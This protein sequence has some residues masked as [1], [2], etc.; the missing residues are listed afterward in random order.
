MNY[1][2]QVCEK[3]VQGI[4]LRLDSLLLM[5]QDKN[6]II[7]IERDMN[8]LYRAT[9]YGGFVPGALAIVYLLENFYL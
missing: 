9:V 1:A 8:N 3:N 5:L 4:A 6:Q 7:G 2:I